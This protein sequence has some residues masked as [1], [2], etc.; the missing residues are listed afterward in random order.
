MTPVLAGRLQTRLFLLATVGVLWTAVLTPLLPVP[1]GTGIGTTYR[2]TFENLGLMAGFGLLWEL[3]YHLLQQLRWDKDWPTLL[4]LV[5]VV[6]EAVLLW[7]VDHWLRVLRGTDGFAAPLL[8]AFVVHV[9]TTWLVMWLFVQGPVRVLHVRWRFEGGRVL[10]RRREPRPAAELSTSDRPRQR[11]I[12]A[13]DPGAEV[14]LTQGEPR[15]DRLVTGAL[16]PNGHFGSA[17]VPYCLT[18]GAVVAPQRPVLGTRPPLGLLITADGGTH[19]LDGDLSLIAAD[20]GLAFSPD[21]EVSGPVLADIRVVGWQAVV[22]S[23]AGPVV[24]L[25]PDRTRLGIAANV[26]VPL[27]PGSTLVVGGHEVRYDSPYTSAVDIAERRDPPMTGVVV[28]VV[29]R[30][31]PAARRAAAAAAVV[32][33][34]V[35][36]FALVDHDGSPDGDRRAGTRPPVLPPPLS[37]FTVP[38]S[39]PPPS[40][41]GTGTPTPSIVTTSSVSIPPAPLPDPTPDSP[42]PTS[43]PG[44][45]TSTSA[46]PT[47][48]TSPPTSSPVPTPPSSGSPVPVAPVPTAEL[49]GVDLMGMAQCIMGLLG[50]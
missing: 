30:M 9:V 33:A 41:R 42:P 48:P 31:S 21:G 2:M 26:P 20:D 5:T 50:G 37:S 17:D 44:G 18:C 8:P 29:R 10:R 35:I 23:A 16:C 4:G 25:L 13:G 38:P 27:V 46:V 14:G 47:S 1:L 34:G 40:G 12:M 15:D 19:L 11:S 6:N 45:G 3:L 49:C 24:L 22:S 32:L 36:T 28:P 39:P 43:G 7:F